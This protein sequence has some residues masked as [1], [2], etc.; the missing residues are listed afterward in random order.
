MRSPRLTAFF[1]LKHQVPE[2]L[3]DGK[4]LDEVLL[5]KGLLLGAIVAN[6]GGAGPVGVVDGKE[7]P[8]NSLSRCS[9]I[10]H[11]LT[12]GHYQLRHDEQS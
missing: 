7:P 1:V 4:F 3:A 10:G 8:A 5:T 11:L 6:G 9:S 2:T 12:L